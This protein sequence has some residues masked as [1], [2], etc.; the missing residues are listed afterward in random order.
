MYYN[1]PQ[2][3]RITMSH[4]SGLPLDFVSK[5]L[6]IKSWLKLDVLLNIHLY[7]N[8]LNKGFKNKES[9]GFT[10]EKIKSLHPLILKAIKGR[11]KPFSLK[12]Y[13]VNY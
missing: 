1:G 8:Y 3:S 2:W 11:K 13:W 5:Q 7:A 6:P 9:K 12:N 4:I 10:L